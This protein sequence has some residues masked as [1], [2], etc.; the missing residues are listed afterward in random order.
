MKIHLSLLNTNQLKTGSGEVIPVEISW[1][2]RVCWVTQFRVTEYS[3]LLH[4]C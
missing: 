4:V 1:D 2:P 3:M